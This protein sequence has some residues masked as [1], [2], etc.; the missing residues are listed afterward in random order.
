[1]RL[2][3]ARGG[4]HRGET[5][6]PWLAYACWPL[7]AGPVLVAC[8]GPSASTASATDADDLL[9]VVM[10]QEREDAAVQEET[11]TMTESP[12]NGGDVKV[13]A[14]SGSPAETTE[15]ADTP[16]ALVSLV[17]R[18]VLPAAQPLTSVDAKLDGVLL[19]LV[20][21]RRVGGEAGLLAYVER[22]QQGLSIDRLQVEI[23]CGS[24]GAAATVREQVAEAG[25]TVTTSFENHVWA[26]L[27]LDRIEALAAT[28]EVWSM[29]VSQAVYRPDAR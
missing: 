29:A 9:P 1:M 22:H 6:R 25:G 8:A 2:K 17:G 20:R 5:G 12:E 16:P 23:V 7:V 18:D 27:P 4:G 28:E 15:A 14:S 21:A 11:V 24:T 10:S 26:E 13:P 3:R 19:E